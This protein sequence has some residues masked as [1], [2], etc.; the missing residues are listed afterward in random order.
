MAE[1]TSNFIKE[2]WNEELVKVNGRFLNLQNE[3][4]SA[5]HLIFSKL[6]Y[7]T[8]N[9]A[10]HQDSLSSRFKFIIVRS[11][12]WANSPFRDIS[13]RAADVPADLPNFDSGFSDR[14]PIPFVN[15]LFEESPTASYI[16][17][18]LAT[19]ES[20]S[21]LWSLLDR[22]YD[23]QSAEHFEHFKQTL[24]STLEGEVTKLNSYLQT[25]HSM[26][27][28][29]AEKEAET[30]V[31]DSKAF[32]I[33]NKLPAPSDEESKR[34]R[35][36]ITIAEEVAD[37]LDLRDKEMATILTISIRTYHR[38]KLNGLLSS[39]ASERLTLLKELA[40][41]GLDVFENQ[42]TFNKWLRLPLRELS[43][44]SPLNSL[45]TATGFNQVKTILQRIDYGVYS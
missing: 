8:R 21:E 20:H 33:N 40:A 5:Q 9:K 6:A 4:W 10:L 35:L 37:V 13:L 43:N 31:Q 36:P 7:S 42:S 11:R 12:T 45:D 19:F 38:L 3:V 23:P 25:L 27:A 22:N 30:P 18:L 26:L 34:K 24:I 44:L 15:P 14:L 1:Q 39:V 2:L 32:I 41:Y 16:A 28:G 17:K 29:L